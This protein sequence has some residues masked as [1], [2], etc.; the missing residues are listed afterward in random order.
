M[1]TYEDTTTTFLKVLRQGDVHRRDSLGHYVGQGKY[2]SY[3]FMA[4]QTQMGLT[5]RL[6]HG[7]PDLT[8]LP[9]ST[10]KLNRLYG[11]LVD[12]VSGSKGELLTSAMEW[13]TSLDMISSRVTQIG[14]A[15]LALRQFKFKKV[16]TILG[17]P[18]PAKIQKIQRQPR[19]HQK[20]T[21]PTE[22]WLEYWMGW[23][24][25]IGDVANAVDTLQKGPGET[26]HFRVGVAD[27][28]TE[29]RYLGN[30]GLYGLSMK[31]PHGVAIFDITRR[32]KFSAYADMKVTNHNLH[33]ADQLGF[34]NPA[35]TAWQMLPFSFMVDWFANVGTVIGSLTDF[36]GVEF[37]NTGTAESCFTFTNCKEYSPEYSGWTYL[38]MK[39]SSNGGSTMQKQRTPGALPK[40]RLQI[41]MLDK[42]SKSRAA[43]SISLLVEIFLRKK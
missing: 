41:K 35:L 11:K 27:E 40:P 12:E 15:Y 30:Y 25:M 43:T 2:Y 37:T 4:S 8:P 32:G 21:T 9:L 39:Q 22:L 20:I 38:Y 24:P 7:S 13:R 28:V 6:Y 1:K 33:L 18:V 42:L 5:N 16:A 29:K 36:V 3:R 17:I 19:K 26:K 14:R 10:S 34:T 23:A 31:P